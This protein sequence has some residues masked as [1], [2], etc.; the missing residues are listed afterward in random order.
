V[1]LGYVKI[2]NVPVGNLLHDERD[3]WFG[4]LT[5]LLCKA[6][7]SHPSREKGDY[8]RASFCC[9]RA[10]PHAMNKNHELKTDCDGCKEIIGFLEMPDT[11]QH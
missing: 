1:L 11:G 8:E 3:L 6:I 7:Y 2:V 4:H 5:N 9:K 10:L